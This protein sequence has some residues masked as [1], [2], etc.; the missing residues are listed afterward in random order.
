MLLRLLL[1]AM[2]FLQVAQLR[3]ELEWSVSYRRGSLFFLITINLSGMD[4]MVMVFL[5]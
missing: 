5:G 2:D 3:R 1:L 4:G